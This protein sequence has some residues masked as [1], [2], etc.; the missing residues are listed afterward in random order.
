M[1]FQ[2]PKGAKLSDDCRNLLV[3][4]LQRDPDVRISFESFLAHPFI[5]LEHAPSPKSLPKAVRRMS[6]FSL[7]HIVLNMS[8]LLVSICTHV[9]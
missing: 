7:I 5:D 1:I 3:S 9:V 8:V 6:I 2:I 4:L